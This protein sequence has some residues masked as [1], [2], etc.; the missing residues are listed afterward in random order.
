MARP[1]LP[2]VVAKSTGA[3]DKNPQRFRN[4][5]PP[6]SL[7]LGMAPRYMDEMQREAWNEFADEMPWLSRADRVVVEVAARL[8]AEMQLPDFP[9]A[10]YAQL[11]MCLSSMGGTPADRS[12]IVAPE[13]EE[14]DPLAKYAN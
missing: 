1:R 11:R 14:D 13:Q 5:K 2:E 3:V 12:K 6:K 8:R 7:P 9:M 10:G 4:R